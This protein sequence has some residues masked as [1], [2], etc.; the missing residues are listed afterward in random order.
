ME[1]KDLLKKAI[2][3]D[4][5]PVLPKKVKGCLVGIDGNAYCLMGYF[6]QQAR[7]QGWSKDEIDQ[8]ITEAKSLNYD[9]LVTTLDSYL[10]LE[11][12]RDDDNYFME[13]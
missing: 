9:H 11:E 3:I 10:E 4:K 6:Q 7:R 8:V 5:T 2:K 13:D 12:L 1:G